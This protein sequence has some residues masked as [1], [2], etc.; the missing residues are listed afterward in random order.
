MFPVV[1]I[2][3]NT[4]T[5]NFKYVI[6]TVTFLRIILAIIQYHKWGRKD[7]MH[8]WFAFHHQR[9][10]KA[11]AVHQILCCAQV[12]MRGLFYLNSIYILFISSKMQC[13]L[14]L[15]S[16]LNIIQLTSQ[17]KRKCDFKKRRLSCF[18]RIGS[19]C[20]ISHFP[21]HPPVSLLDVPVETKQSFS[22]P[23]PHRR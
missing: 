16:L 12:V 14:A 9:S 6:L 7:F 1:E 17:Y 18:P 3:V 19:P 22:V 11:V 8:K 23:K 21:D 20:I 13:A 2:T 5:Y 4:S 15:I 10:L